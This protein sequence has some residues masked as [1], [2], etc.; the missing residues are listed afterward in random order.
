MNTPDLIPFADA[1]KESGDSDVALFGYGLEF[2]K[3]LRFFV[4]VPERGAAYQVPRKALQHFQAG[5]TEYLATNLREHWNG[6]P[7]AEYL[8]LKDRLFV[9][10]D[11]WIRRVAD[12]EELAQSIERISVPL[13][14]G[15]RPVQEVASTIARAVLGI[16]DDAED[17][18]SRVT[19]PARRF[20]Q[21]VGDWLSLILRL[22]NEGT[23]TL[24]DQGGMSHSGPFDEGFLASAELAV[25]NPLF[26]LPPSGDRTY[27][28]RIWFEVFSPGHSLRT[29]LSADGTATT[30]WYPDATVQG[31]ND[32][33]AA[34][35]R[36]ADDRQ[37]STKGGKAHVLDG[38]IA[39]AQSRCNDQ[40]SFLQVFAQLEVMASNEEPPLLMA[41]PDGLKYL[42]NGVTKFYRRDALRKK[43][44]RAAEREPK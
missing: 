17:L 40:A 38:V 14:L 9:L 28:R 22:V 30:A 42:D 8:I 6:Q 27:P 12:A 37:H 43:L 39:A 34:V 23:L 25:A 33:P 31:D 26:V 44:K 24:Y 18:S 1:R 11:D 10:A 16:T 3:P 21:E 4:I 15:F 19:Q 5:A 7:L 41:T 32:P 29:V 20:H 2:G 36:V 35:Y 13:R